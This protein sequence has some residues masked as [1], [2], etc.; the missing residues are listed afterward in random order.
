MIKAK[1]IPILCMLLFVG[2]VAH[3]CYVD[4]RN[5]GRSDG[6]C[7]SQQNAQASVAAM[8]AADRAIREWEQRRAEMNAERYGDFWGG[9]IINLNTGAWYS[10]ANYLESSAAELQLVRACSHPACAVVTLFK[11]TCVAQSLGNK[12]EMYWADDVKPSVAQQKAK[13]LCE[14]KSTGCDVSEQ[15]I[16]CS[17][18]NYTDRVTGEVGAGQKSL[19]SMWRHYRHAGSLLGILAPDLMGVAEVAKPQATLNPL[20]LQLAE[21]PRSVKE[22]MSLPDFLARVQQQRAVPKLYVS[23]ALSTGGRFAKTYFGVTPAVAE[24]EALSR[25]GKSDCQ[26]LLTFEQHLC[27]AQS[28]GRDNNGANYD[29]MVAAAT[30][31][32]AQKL[33]LTSCRKNAGNQ[34]QIAQSFCPSVSLGKRS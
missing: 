34:C 29:Y 18:F 3:A 13:K 21:Q 1:A 22:T 5:P 6:A 31:D 9:V 10:A 27:A 28:W 30:E 11:N 24:N 32:E 12:G 33:A 2:G 4:P 15:H 23:T 16:S 19:L 26:V 8:E 7:L 17:G 20:A 14:A 25:C